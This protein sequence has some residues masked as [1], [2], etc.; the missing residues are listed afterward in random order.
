MEQQIIIDTFLEIFFDGPKAWIKAMVRDKLCE[1]VDEERINDIVLDFSHMIEKDSLR[2]DLRKNMEQICKALREKVEAA[3]LTV[4]E[5]IEED[6]KLWLGQDLNMDESH[7]MRLC[8]AFLGMMLCYIKVKDKVLY[9]DLQLNQRMRLL[10]KKVEKLI[11]KDGGGFGAEDQ[12]RKARLHSC[13]DAKWKETIRVDNVEKMQD[14]AED[15]QR[16]EWAYQQ[17]QQVVFLYGDPGIGKTVLA[18]EYANQGG[19]NKVIFLSYENSF[20]YTL[21]KLLEDN[22]EGNVFD[23]FDYFQQLPYE[24]KKSALLIIDNF[25]DDAYE[26]EIKRYDE[27]LKGDIYA[28]LLDTG[29]RL[30]ITTR[31]EVKGNQQEV[32]P[33]KKVRE[34]FL[35]CCGDEKGVCKDPRID[36]LIAAVGG[37]TLLVT[38]LAYIWEASTEKEKESLLIKLKRGEMA[39]DKHEIAVETG[40]EYPAGTATFYQQLEAILYY[41]PV[42]KSEGRKKWMASAALLPLE[43]MD[44][45]EFLSIMQGMD[46]KELYDLVNRRWISQD[47]KRV[48]VHAGI[49]EVT[50]RNPQITI[51][52]NCKQFCYAIGKKLDVD[53]EE[54]LQER[55]RYR[56]YAQEIY[57]VFPKEADEEILWMYYNLSDIYDNL[58]EKGLANQ[59]GQAV[60]DQIRVF[61]SDTLKTARILSGI[62]YSKIQ[63]AHHEED[64]EEPKEMLSRAEDILREISLEERSALYEKVRG[65]VYSNQG[66]HKQKMADILKK[67]SKEVYQESEKMHE[68]TLKYR[69]EMVD[70]WERKVPEHEY[71]ELLKD[72]AL[73]HKNVATEQ[74]HL[75]KYKEAIKNHKKAIQI[76]TSLGEKS[77]CAFVQKLLAGCVVAWYKSKLEFRT[78]LIE[79]ILEFYPGMAETF[80]KNGQLKFLEESEDMFQTLKKIIE[81]DKR[82]E[83]YREKVREI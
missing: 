24:E 17:G 42:L 21:K 71:H 58:K 11:E 72:L 43:G 44:K 20:E 6:V 10:E 60:Y 83:P 45:E 32:Q 69:E 77:S 54:T 2:E 40:R 68:K 59:L 78:E 15:R 66:A 74:F 79:E 1:M 9:R 70:K 82:G 28:R 65:K 8:E 47:G 31:I 36:A 16:I 3:D 22:V 4:L 5:Q 41:G 76:F 61:S 25:N 63:N 75:G 46:Q 52:D 39:E 55:I 64:L 33:L 38:L 14:R 34:L 67:K 19:Y 37:N 12:Q 49:R 50:R 18:K 53:Q 81:I 56:A 80:Q 62:A 57:Q 26:A 30:L 27:E 23:I 7:Q 73:S 51:F 48:F 35:S 13:L 29:L